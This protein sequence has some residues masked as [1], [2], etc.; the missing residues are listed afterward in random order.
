MKEKVFGL[1]AL[2]LLLGSVSALTDTNQTVFSITVGSVCSL[3]SN[4]T[5]HDFTTVGENS[6]SSL[7]QINLTNTG[8]T[9]LNLSV[10][11]AGDWSD[12][13][14]H[15]IPV[16][17]LQW[18]STNV[19]GGC[20]FAD[21]AGTNLTNANVTVYNGNLGQFASIQMCYKA[22]VPPGQFAATYTITSYHEAVC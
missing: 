11:A 21:G 19:T 4:T 20:S 13:A 12:G 10:W 16:G 9:P 2:L 8:N 17:Y 18:N 22:Y 5:T 15:S 7:A 14:G 1:L 3:A 6:Y